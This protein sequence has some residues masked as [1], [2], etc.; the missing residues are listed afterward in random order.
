MTEIISILVSGISGIAGGIGS[1][2]TELVQQIFLTGAGTDGDPYKLSIF[3]G[4]ICI[5]AGISLA[6]GLSRMVVQ[7]VQSLG[8]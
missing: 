5:F 7:W 8:N 2:L 4:V 6:V 1:G 3:G